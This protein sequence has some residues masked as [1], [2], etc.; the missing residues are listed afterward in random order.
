KNIF[1]FSVSFFISNLFFL[2][3][4]VLI[5]IYAFENNVPLPALS[6]ELY[7]TLA[8]NH[9]GQFTGI[10]FMIGIIAAAFSSADSALTAL[11]TSFCVDILRLPERKDMN[12]GKVRFRVHIGFTF[13]I[14]LTIVAFDQINDR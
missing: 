6:D 1:W 3:L 5:Y 13:V 12:Q 10:V 9:F 2:A 8:I 11:T 4:G 7:P 14:F